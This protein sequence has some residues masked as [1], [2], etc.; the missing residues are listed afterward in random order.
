MLE[1]VNCYFFKVNF[2]NL[3]FL[4]VLRYSAVSLKNKE[5]SSVEG[6]DRILQKKL[7]HGVDFIKVGCMAQIIEIALLKL[8]AQRKWRSTPL[9]RFS[10]VGCRVQ[11]SL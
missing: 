9:K 2:K 1:S 10:K 8:G 6:I 3:N 4:L 5:I 11:N 7:C